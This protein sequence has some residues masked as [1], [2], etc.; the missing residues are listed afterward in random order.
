MHRML[1]VIIVVVHNVPHAQAYVVQVV[2]IY[3]MQVAAEHAADALNSVQADAGIRVA[4][5]V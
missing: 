2:L 4:I 1:V 5:N 3:V